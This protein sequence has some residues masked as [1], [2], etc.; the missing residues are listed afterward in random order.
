MRLLRASF[1]ALYLLPSSASSAPCGD[2]VTPQVVRLARPPMPALPERDRVPF[3]SV[4]ATVTCVIG[5]QG[6]LSRCLS[7]L[8]DERGPALAAYVG[9]W[10]ILSHNAG[11]CPVRGRRF[12]VKF[13]LQDVG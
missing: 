12:A 1:I 13:D 11:A 4:T 9:R 2:V 5:S 6:K 7:K 10:R 8:T 3:P